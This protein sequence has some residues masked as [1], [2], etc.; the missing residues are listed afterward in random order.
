[1]KPPLAQRQAALRIRSAELRVEIALQSRALR[2]PLA[3]ADRVHDGWQWL[4]SHRQWVWGVAGVWALLR[5]RRALKV[6]GRGWLGWRTVRRW[7]PWLSA[8][9]P[10][11]LA[12]LQRRDAAADS[13][14]TA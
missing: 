6:L 2:A 7:Q 3:A 1:M 14:D 12:A 11:V 9:M 8:V 10:A 13:G 5:P 4:S